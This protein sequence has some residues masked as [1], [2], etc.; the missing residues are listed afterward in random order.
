MIVNNLPPTI[1]SASLDR[2]VISAGE[3]VTLTGTVSDPG[4]LDTHTVRIVWGD[5]G[6]SDGVPVDP[7]TRTFSVQYVYQLKSVD[8]PI[9]DY[10]VNVVATDDDGAPA[11]G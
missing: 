11:P 2:T 10:L 8:Q 5:G 6:V 4:L 1:A 9:K 3:A 7:L